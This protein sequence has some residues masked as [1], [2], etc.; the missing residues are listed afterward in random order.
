MADYPK[1]IAYIS[2]R[3][4]ARLKAASTLLG[5]PEWRLLE[6]SFETYWKSLSPKD[7]KLA[8]EMVRRMVK[9]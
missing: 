7:R 4:K 2:P 5:K 8:D 3:N 1:V 9:R 6:E